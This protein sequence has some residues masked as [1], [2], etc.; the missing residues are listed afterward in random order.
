MII[1]DT[2]SLGEYIRLER[3]KLMVTQRD[4]ALACGTGLRFIVDLEKGKATCHTG[5]VLEVIRALGLQIKLE[6]P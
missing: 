1:K 6:R 3:K 2:V 4:L 5:K